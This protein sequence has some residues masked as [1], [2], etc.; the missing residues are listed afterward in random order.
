[1]DE[2]LSKSL[3]M[4]L[5]DEG[6]EEVLSAFSPQSFQAGET[7]IQAGETGDELYLLLAGKVRVWTGDGPSSTERTL[8]V[9][10]P[11]EHFGEAAMVSGKPRNAT[12]TALTYVETLVLKRDD[13]ERLAPRHPAL[14][15]NISRSLTNRLSQMNTFVSRRSKPKRGIHSLGIVIDTPAGWP[16]CS[17]LLAQLRKLG[18][19]PNPMLVCD[20]KPQ[21]DANTFVP[22]ATDIELGDVAL[23]V[24]NRSKGNSFA[25]VV[26]DGEQAA[27]VTV[28]ECDRVVFALSGQHALASSVGK[29]A[30]GIPEHRVPIAAMMYD[31]T[32]E[33]AN[34][35]TLDDP[36]IK[37]I[38][39]GY[40]PSV[41]KDSHS[42]IVAEAGA[43]RLARALSGIR[44]GL[45][46]GGGG[47]RGIAHIGVAQVFAQKGIVFDTVSATSA[48]SIIAGA[49]CGGHSAEQTG[50][51]FR[52]DMIPPKFFTWHPTLKQIWLF[53]S[54]RGGRF[55]KKL[56]RY[57]NHLRFDQA[58]F[59]LAI[60]TLDL[61]SG[62]QLIRREGDV[63]HSILESINHPVFGAPVKRNN[64]LLVDGGVLM[65]VPASVLRQEGCDCVISVDV[66]SALATDFAHDKNGKLR[67][68]SYIATLLRTMEL[69]RRHSSDLHAQESD[70]I[71]IPDTETF[72]I[73]DF[74]A[75]DP[76]IEAGIKAGEE[77]YTKV[78]EMIDSFLTITTN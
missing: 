50:Q 25:F 76:L 67:K 29:L 10:G 8:T 66:G 52:D 65:N 38:R 32:A 61:V 13:Y 63:V 40:Q 15:E 19:S 35:P 21:F 46:L 78:G 26:A 16:L 59:P 5:A 54:F 45:A 3:L 37:S 2:T 53:H 7:I 17:A 28:K 75:V 74:H 11:S 30:L 23:E 55:E 33:L 49:L 64:Q 18:H 69:S 22:D 36:R 9:L 62:Q 58:D 73:E 68:P 51:F 12:V 20:S 47:A 6:L 39:V 14:L 4:G 41:T 34:R 70:M 44:I 57:L 71:V 42:A 72:D 60:T 48:G 77:N 27:E 24:A 31:S 56:R 43:V 1:M